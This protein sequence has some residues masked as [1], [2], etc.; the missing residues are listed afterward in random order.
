[1]AKAQQTVRE[2][3]VTGDRDYI[4]TKIEG[5]LDIL[6]PE[7]STVITTALQTEVRVSL[8]TAMV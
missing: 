3:D 8:D 6:I 5:H 4:T 7:Y 2:K 1:M